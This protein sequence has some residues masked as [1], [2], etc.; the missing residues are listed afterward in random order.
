MT[1]VGIGN[2]EVGE[3]NRIAERGFRLGIFEFG[4]NT[5]LG[6]SISIPVLDQT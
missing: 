4:F 6:P 5:A 1:E 3:K 2:A